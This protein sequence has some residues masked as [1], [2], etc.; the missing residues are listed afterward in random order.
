MLNPLRGLLSVP[1]LH[2]LYGN[3]RVFM[4]IFIV[5]EDGNKGESVRFANIIEQQDKKI[6]H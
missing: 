2:P 5:R 4:Q 3:V 1:L 6:P